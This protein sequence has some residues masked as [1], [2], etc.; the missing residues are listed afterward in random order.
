VHIPAQFQKIAVCI[1]KHRLVS[2]LIK[3]PTSTVTAVEL[4]RVGGVEALHEFVKVGL[5]SHDNHM[6]VVVH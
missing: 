1:Y 3:V 6:K 5:M 4:N 2:P